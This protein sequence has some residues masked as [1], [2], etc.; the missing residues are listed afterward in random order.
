MN[1]NK[2]IDLKSHS[3]GGI[4]L[5]NN[6]DYNVEKQLQPNRSGIF[7]YFFYIIDSQNVKRRF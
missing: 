5:R 2:V 7:I 6:K 1:T 3:S 4:K